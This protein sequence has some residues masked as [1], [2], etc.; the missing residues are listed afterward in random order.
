MEVV[1]RLE[2]IDKSIKFLIEQL[3]A[4]DKR[5]TSVEEKVSNLQ[6]SNIRYGPILPVLGDDISDTSGY[7]N[8]K[9]GTLK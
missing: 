5:L 1:D 7:I 4:I 9:Y 2:V 8:E 3:S 6:F